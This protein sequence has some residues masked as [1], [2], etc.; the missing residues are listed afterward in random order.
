VRF[1]RR[2][3]IH[4]LDRFGLKF[5]IQRILFNRQRDRL[6]IESELL[7]VAPNVNFSDFSLDWL[8]IAPFVSE[9]RQP[10]RIGGGNYF[11][12]ILE[13]GRE[14]SPEKSFQVYQVIENEQYWKESVAQLVREVNPANILIQVESEPN[15][16][17]EWTIDVLVAQLR[18]LGWKGRIVLLSYDSVFPLHLFR[19]DRV[20]RSDS[21]CVVVTIDRSISGRYRGK[22]QNISQVFLPI[23]LKSY[24][25]LTFECRLV[26]KIYPV[27]FIGAL[28]DYRISE[29]DTLKSMGLD[30][31]VNPHVIGESEGSYL[32]YVRCLS[33]S[34]LTIN[35]SRAH[36]FDIPQ[37]K[38]RMLEAGLFGCVVLTD[39]HS[40]ASKYFQQGKEFLFFDSPIELERI[41]SNLNEL[42]PS[43]QGIAL[44]AQARAKSIMRESFW[45]KLL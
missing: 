19:I 13:S 4:I 31:Q 42:D 27:S 14:L 3:A 35:F 24:E 1:F 17:S 37:L 41:Y 34:L 21:N 33:E 36:V 43:I 11:F 15:G 28:Y 10:W 7:W 30:I 9:K 12:E 6:R 25:F 22:S 18:N 23:S 2:A 38:T 44:A 29:L 39:E 45:E 5:R 8:L 16:D 26:S 20:A 40:H 32:E